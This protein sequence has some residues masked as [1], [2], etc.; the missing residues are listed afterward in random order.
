MSEEE[1]IEQSPGDG[2]TERAFAPNFTGFE[3]NFS[4][5]AFLCVGWGF[6]EETG[7]SNYILH[8]RGS[9]FRTKLCDG[10]PA[11][12]KKNKVIRLVDRLHF[13]Y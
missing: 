13:F 8:A 4:K 5:L 7:C 12:T 6:R 9:C 10:D 11:E 3:W 1:K 2:K